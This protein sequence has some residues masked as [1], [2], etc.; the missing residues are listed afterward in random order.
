LE[1]IGERLRKRRKKLGLTIT[2]ISKETGLSTGNISDL[3]NNKYAP[4]ASAIIALS[5][6]LSISIDQL[7]TGSKFQISDNKEIYQADELWPLSEQEM[8]MLRKYRQFDARDQL[9]IKELIEMK[10]FRMSKRGMSSGSR[11]GGRGSGEEAAAKE[12]A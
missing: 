12:Y 9:D 11:N 8:D 2:A 7:L 3:E 5:R 6:V 1:S 4:S 10:Y